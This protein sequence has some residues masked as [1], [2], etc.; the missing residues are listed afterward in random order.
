MIPNF[1]PSGNL[2]VGIYQATLEEIRHRFGQTS[3]QRGTLTNQL[4]RVID[5]ARSTGHLRQVFIWG[6]YVT[7]KIIPND[8]DL[9]QFQIQFHHEMVVAISI[10]LEA[11]EVATTG[12]SY[13]NSEWV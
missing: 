12:M 8:I 13:F 2:P 5:L 3:H 4:Q 10:A 11:T 9:Y 6:S 7:N 1:D